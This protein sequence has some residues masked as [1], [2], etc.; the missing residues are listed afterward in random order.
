M[1]YGLTTTVEPAEEPVSVA[2]TKARLVIDDDD[3]AIASMITAARQSIEARTS[4]ALISQTMR[5]T[6]DR[7]PGPRRVAGGW[8]GGDLDLA[9]VL[10][11]IQIPR[12]PVASVSSITYVDEQGVTQTLAESAYTV[13][14]STLIARVV[15]AYGTD[16]PTTRE[17]PAAVAVTFV[18]G[19]GTRDAVPRPL[20][21]AIIA[22]VG[23]W[24]A[25][26]EAV[27][28]GTIAT[29]LPLSVAYMIGPYRI[30]MPV[31]I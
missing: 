19:Y 16:W 15:P 5:M 1:R 29:A 26:R 13:D 12:A 11:M 28:T 23:T 24:D 2:E 30:P 4:R 18:A 10:G 21:E 17:V 6:L 14:T 22:L 7:F 31:P 8:S 20:C 3:P 9:T 25:N 27:I